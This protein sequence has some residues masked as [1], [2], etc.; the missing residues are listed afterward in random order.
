[1]K[2]TKHSWPILIVSKQFEMLNDEGLRLRAL[3]EELEQ[4]QECSVLT[5][6]S[7]EDALEMFASRADLGVVVIDWDI[8]KEDVEE[9]MPPEELLDGIRRRNR[10]IPVVLLTERREIENIPT[11]VLGR[12]DDCI[13]KTAD[14]I[15][16]LAGRIE[17]LLVD[18]VYSV[19]PGFFGMLVEYSREYKYAWHT[20][21]HMGG[22]GFLK[23]P[24]GV[25]MHKFFGENVF[26]SD[27]SISV[28]ELGSLLDHSGV[29]GDAERNSAR[30]FG[31]DL[32][33]Y[34]L[35]GTSNVNQIIWRSQLIRDDIAFVDR[36]CHKSLNY[37]MV[38]TEAYPVY[39]VPRR[40]KRGIIGPCRLSEFSAKTIRKKIQ[41]NK[42]IPAELKK[43]AVKMSA[44]TN[45]TYDGICYNVI[46][47]KKELKKSVEN[48]H[49]DEAWYAYARFHPMYKDH[50]GMADDEVNTEHPPIFSSQSTHKLL[51]A[52][53]QASMLHVKNGSHVSVN[54][55]EL[56]E[57]YMMH[58]STS[59]QYSMIA[60]LDVATKMMDDSGEIII[61]DTILEAVH[62]RRKVARIAK[63]MRKA[64]EWFF[65][66]WQPRKVI[67]NGKPC[68]FENVP[69]EYLAGNQQPWIFSPKDDWHGF[70]DMEEN[71][72]MLDP[73]KLTFTTPGLDEKGGMSE[74]G[75]PAAIVTNYLIRH[76]IVCEKTDYYSFL[77]LNSMGTT[78]AKQGALLSGLLKFKDLYD[79]NAPLELVLPELTRD[80]P[81]YRGVGL[82]DHCNAIHHHTREHNLLDKMQAAFQ[83]IP[84]QAM[85]PADAYHAVV[86]K[87]VE[88]VELKDMR[89]RVPAVMTVPYPP[90]IPVMM[91][92]EIMNK[93][94]AP[95]FDYLMARQDFENTFPGYE[96]DI[97]GVERI[98]RDG[99]KYFTIMCVKKG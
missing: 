57:S 14:T 97:H 36:N 83:V 33:F 58:G 46:N 30:V 42:L 68:D 49:F 72:A 54:R 60:S 6:Q 47:I 99:K 84:D 64:G 67:Y 44:L 16:F 1:M 82:R 85:K 98:E 2:I 28:P 74:E 7:Y 53:S 4:V 20:P 51:M 21:G 45:S 34:V 39:M 31:A 43:N 17:K 69:A 12:I 52:F 3:E 59:P 78:K 5:S 32:T 73:I 41:D 37:A 27:L 87:N 9:K 11:D 75:I 10:T 61:S 80:N 71:Y 91:G 18:Y 29:V 81:C 89:D 90:G 25:A 79:D 93:K 8:Q 23:S 40:N 76:R 70:E 35:N 95:I 19:Y 96:S 24:A 50:Y 48:L 15:E 22:E 92:G 86:R 55:D 26:R 77:L 65:D 66:M 88:Y 62:I 13:W 63:E 94:A 38:I 56:N